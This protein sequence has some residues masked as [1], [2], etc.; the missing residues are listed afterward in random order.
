MRVLHCSAAY[1]DFVLTEFQKILDK[2]EQDAALRAD[3]DERIRKWAPVPKAQIDR[4]RTGMLAIVVGVED[5]AQTKLELEPKEK[6][7]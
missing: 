7:S 5:P 4:R 1:R 2:V 6:A 3:D